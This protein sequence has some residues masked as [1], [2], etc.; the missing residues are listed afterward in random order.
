M[1]LVQ[2]NDKLTFVLLA[3][4]LS[5]LY[6]PT[7]PVKSRKIPPI[8]RHFRTPFVSEIKTIHLHNTRNWLP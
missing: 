2:Y 5:N 1:S 6:I 8:V 3:N 4:F 7:V